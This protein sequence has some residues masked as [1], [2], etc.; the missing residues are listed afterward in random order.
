VEGELAL[1]VQEVFERDPDPDAETYRL[2][3]DRI[4]LEPMLR[5]ALLLALPLAPLCDEACP[6]PDPE[7]HPVGTGDDEPAADPRW[8]ALDSLHFD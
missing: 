2:D 5:D 3:G 8:S 6:G 7:A 1:D 4:D